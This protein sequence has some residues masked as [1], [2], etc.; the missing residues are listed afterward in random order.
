MIAITIKNM[1]NFMNK[2]LISDTFD[3]FQVSEASVTTFAT[4][5]VDGSLHPDF[6]GP[7][8]AEEL[9][10]TGRTQ[11]LWHDVKPFCFSIIKGKRTPL[12]FKFVLMLPADEIALL[13]AKSGLAIIPE[14]VFGLYLNCQ[15]NGEAITLTTGTSLRIFTLDKSLDRAWDQMLEEFLVQQDID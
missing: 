1:K 14:D 11:V 2:L 9:R 10:A 3:R 7:A 4:F 15:Y 13:I 5:S 8:A 12:S 6:Y